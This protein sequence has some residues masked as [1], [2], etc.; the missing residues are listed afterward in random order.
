MFV[1]FRLTV[2]LAGIEYAFIEF[3]VT[4]KTG[5]EKYWPHIKVL[6]FDFNNKHGKIQ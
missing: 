3:I 4:K 6:F 1:I 5:S 2:Y